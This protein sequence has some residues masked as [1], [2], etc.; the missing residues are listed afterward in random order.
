MM[1]TENLTS[2]R[3]FLATSAAAAAAAHP[4]ARAAAPSLPSPF[5]RY[6]VRSP[7]GIKML[8]SYAVAIEAMLKLPPTDPHNWYRNALLHTMDCPHG[9]WWFL[10][11]HRGYMGLF[12][13]T[14]RHYSGNPRFAFPYWN[15]TENAAV[16]PQFFEGVL[17]PKHPDYM[18]PTRNSTTPF[19]VRSRPGSSP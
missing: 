11:W 6:D 10:L 18:C 14:V 13:R 12:E 4:L 15:W 1:I 9:N 16:P 19:G 17:N 5:K 7:E 3:S 2:R 8:E